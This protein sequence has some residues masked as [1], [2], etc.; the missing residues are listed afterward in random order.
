M[1]DMARRGVGRTYIAKEFKSLFRTP[2]YLMQCVLPSFLFPIIFSI[3]IYREMTASSSVEFELGEIAKL[4]GEL[5][6]SGF[7]IGIILTL[8][9][10]LYLF[11]FMSVTSISREG[12]NALFMKYIPI[13]LSK[14]YKYKAIPGFLINLVPL[15]YVL[16]VLK[17]L[18]PTLDLIVFMEI[19]LLALLS[20][21]FVNYFSVVIDLMN[22][23]LHWTTEYAVVK[24]NINMLYSFILSLVLIG[25]IMGVSSYIDDYNILTLAL[26]GIM[27]FALIVFEVFLRR[28]ENKIFKKIA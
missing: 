28:Y 15:I 26:S 4:A 13:R 19:I 18:L 6:S 27:I 14:Q 21:F 11:N 16:V 3:P 22:P 1:K 20:N 2:V 12:E 10:F 7:G 9:N 24:Q 17:I 23:K 8:I 25:I 5:L